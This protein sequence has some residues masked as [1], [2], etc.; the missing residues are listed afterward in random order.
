MVLQRPI[1]NLQIWHSIL[2]FKIWYL[3]IFSIIIMIIFIS[4]QMAGKRLCFY[5]TLWV[6]IYYVERNNTS[7]ILVKRIW[8]LE[9]EKIAKHFIIICS[10][11]NLV[12]IPKICNPIIGFIVRRAQIT[13]TLH[14]AISCYHCRE[15]NRFY[16]NTY[17]LNSWKSGGSGFSMTLTFGAG[18][19]SGLTG[20]WTP[21]SQS[22]FHVSVIT[23]YSLG[24]RGSESGSFIALIRSFLKCDGVGSAF[25][26]CR[27]RFDSNR[28]PR[29]IPN[30][31]TL[32]TEILALSKEI[33]GLTYEEPMD[34]FTQ[35]MNWFYFGSLFP[36]LMIW[37][38]CYLIWYSRC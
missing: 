4:L 21:R 37:N 20:T 12:D 10:Q 1:H 32:K 33:K 18:R 30:R 9:N 11:K 38:K 6:V 31:D 23:Q 24:V 5:P 13:S 16:L 15:G 8:C 36:L 22:C 26:I 25:G 34:L 17:N 14:L 2:F 35:S 27:H 28:L 7:K 19:D 29:G 3:M